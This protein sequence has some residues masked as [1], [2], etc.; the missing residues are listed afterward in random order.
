MVKRSFTALFLIVAIS[1]IFPLHVHA[2]LIYGPGYFLRNT[3]QSGVILVL[4]AT[5]VLAAVAL[6]VIRIPVKNKKGKPENVLAKDPAHMPNVKPVILSIIAF[7][8]AQVVVDLMFL[9]VVGFVDHPF[10][11]LAYSIIY[12][13]KPNM[14]YVYFFVCGLL[15]VPI[16]FFLGMIG[17]RVFKFDAKKSV[18]GA[19]IGG[20]IILSAFWFIFVYLPDADYNSSLVYMIFHV[21]AGWAY[22]HID[23]YYSGYMSIANLF[24]AVLPP[25]AFAA[26]MRVYSRIKRNRQ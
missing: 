26:G 7:L 6:V 8:L 3:P 21:P 12:N 2:D 10:S 23:S 14:I 15:F 25:L 18:A 13:Y 9:F 24:P 17:S 11:S 4:T 19:L 16:Y 20:I 1:L 5:I 22:S